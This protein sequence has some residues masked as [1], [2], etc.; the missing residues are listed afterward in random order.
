MLNYNV[1]FVLMDQKLLEEQELQQEMDEVLP[2]YDP[3]SGVNG[4]DLVLF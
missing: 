1:L 3:L 2:F 4:G